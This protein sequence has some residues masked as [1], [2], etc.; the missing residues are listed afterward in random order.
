MVTANGE[1]VSQDE[2]IE[3]RCG[4]GARSAN[5]ADLK[6]TTTPVTDDDIVIGYQQNNS[7]T[8]KYQ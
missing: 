8:V 7:K 5:I 3:S 1:N 6:M 4:V 2:R